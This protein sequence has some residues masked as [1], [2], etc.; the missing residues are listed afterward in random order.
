MRVARATRAKGHQVQPLVF[1]ALGG[2]HHDVVKLI[3]QTARKHGNNRLGAD[4]LS[5]PWCARSFKSIHT[6]RI[7]VAL[8]LASVEEILD[9]ILQDGA[10]QA[11]AGAA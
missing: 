1:E 2:F 4:H 10:A 9:T 8:H 7:S 6:Q 11:A 5:A 3:D